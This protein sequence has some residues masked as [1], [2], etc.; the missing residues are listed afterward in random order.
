VKREHYCYAK[1]GS[2]A[3]L[4]ALEPLTGKRL[5]AV[6]QHRGKK[7]YALFFKQLAAAYPW[8][9]EDPGGAG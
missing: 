7:E 8:G 2:C 3:L 5:A 9:K 6:Y 4:A 1:N